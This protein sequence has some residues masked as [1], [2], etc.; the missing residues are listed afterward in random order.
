MRQRKYTLP[1]HTNLA[2]QGPR[3]G[4]FFIDVAICLGIGIAFFFG[5][6]RL[7]LNPVARPYRA[8]LIQEELNSHLCYRNEETGAVDVLPSD[9]SFEKYRDTIAYYFMNYLTGENLDEPGTGS[10]LAN[11][12]IKNE[13]GEMVPKK[14]YYTIPWYNYNI[15]GIKAA[16]PESD[17]E[18]LFTYVKVG[19]VYDKTQLGI[20]KD[21]SKV[22]A[23][24]VD[25]YM[26]NA[27]VQTYI[28]D[29]NKLSY[30]VDL[31]NKYTFIYSLEFVLSG[32]MGA[33]ITYVII[34]LFF[35][36]G[37]TIGKKV[38]KLALATSDGYAFHNKQLI[39]RV[40]PLIV[41]MLAFLIP[42]WNDFFLLLLIPLIIFLVSFALAMA[43]PKKAALH[44]FTARSIVVDDKSSLIFE[45]EMEEDL[46]IRKEDGIIDDEDSV[47][48]SDG[49]EPEISY[50]K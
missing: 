45:N 28:Q 27:Y 18:C 31:S 33:I 38:F 39:M 11:E 23:I 10:R 46:F 35:R 19:D 41:V 30:V 13:K 9:S 36:Q 15:L 3:I 44:D 47:L 1:R 48:E 4:A 43:S 37:R 34:P 20:P 17:P 40:M 12:P 6:F 49:E 26:K 22:A 42:I 29:F 25:K 32:I 16:D 8:E 14:D 50:E 21:P 24:D 7:I 5:C 2:N